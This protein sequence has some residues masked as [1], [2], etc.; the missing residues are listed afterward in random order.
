M[1]RQN[2][3]VALSQTAIRGD[4]CQVK[5]LIDIRNLLWIYPILELQI[6]QKQDLLSLAAIFGNINHR[7]REKFIRYVGEEYQVV[8][9]G[10]IERRSCSCFDTDLAGYPANNFA[11]YRISG[12]ISGQIVNIE[13]FLK[14]FLRIFQFSTNPT[15]ISGRYFTLILYL[16]KKF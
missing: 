10:R 9:R 16:V 3:A 15:N 5:G 12:R 7:R 13:F 6:L 4:I 1:I 2:G 11:R 14:T 8:K